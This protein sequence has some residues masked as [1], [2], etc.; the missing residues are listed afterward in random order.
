MALSWPG[1]NV[2]DVCGFIRRNRVRVSVCQHTGMFFDWVSHNSKDVL[3]HPWARCLT[4]TNSQQRVNYPPQGDTQTAVVRKWWRGVRFREEIRVTS[5]QKSN[6][7][8]F[9]F[10]AFTIWSFFK[11]LLLTQPDIFAK[12]HVKHL[13]SDSEKLYDTCSSEIIP[14]PFELPHKV[15]L[16]IIWLKM[17]F[18]KDNNVIVA[19]THAHLVRYRRFV[20]S[21]RTRV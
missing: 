18:N 10:S 8:T 15:K 17:N 12:L 14:S 7:Q 20:P 21:R 6:L 16:R 9:D 2:N 11:V 3:K 13:Y 1:L 19:C 5:W 4:S